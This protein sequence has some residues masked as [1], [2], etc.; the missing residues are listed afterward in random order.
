[1]NILGFDKFKHDLEKIEHSFKEIKSHVPVILGN[2]AVNH[3]KEGFRYGGYMTDDSAHGWKGRQF[4]KGVG[5]RAILV[6]SGKLKNDIKLT[7]A[8]F[9]RIIIGTTSLTQN[10]ATIQ[11][12][13]GTIRKTEKMT[14]FFWAMY[15]KTKNKGEKEYWKSLAL[16]KGNIKIPERQFLGHSKI[17]IEKLQKEVMNQYEKNKK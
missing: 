14:A 15:M 17:L 8:N 16:H 1:M 7:E 5:Q 3:F 6:K 13:G 12:R 4:T 2:L 10:Y 11:N 9:N